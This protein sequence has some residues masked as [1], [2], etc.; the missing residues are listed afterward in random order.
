VR[1]RSE[2]SKKPQKTP[3]KKKKRED[4]NKQTKRWI[5][6]S[7]LAQGR[8]Q[9]AAAEKVVLGQSKGTFLGSGLQRWTVTEEVGGDTKG[10]KG[11][12]KTHVQNQSKKTNQG[13]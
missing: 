9:N 2:R 12:K 5:L 10:R 13:S 7:G 4:N 1:G 3:H 6:R 11:T 8:G